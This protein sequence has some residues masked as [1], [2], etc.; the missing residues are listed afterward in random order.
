MVILSLVQN[1][2]QSVLHSAV[3]GIR[4]KQEQRTKYPFQLLANY[5]ALL[6][7]TGTRSRDLVGEGLSCTIRTTITCFPMCH[8]P[9]A[10]THTHTQKGA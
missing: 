7:Y 10:P 9:P 1:H 2:T 6:C 3:V 4:M 8:A 5:A